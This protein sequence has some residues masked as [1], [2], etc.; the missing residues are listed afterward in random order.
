MNNTISKYDYEITY[1]LTGT[2]EAFS[3]EEAI[4]LAIQSEEGFMVEDICKEEV[5]VKEEKYK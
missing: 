3:K 5:V 4:E 1:R 2:V